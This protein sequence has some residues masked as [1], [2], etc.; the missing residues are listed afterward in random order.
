MDRQNFD[1]NY[2]D[3]YPVNLM[4]SPF[5]FPMPKL[6]VAETA[7][8]LDYEFGIRKTLACWDLSQI[9][10]KIVSGSETGLRHD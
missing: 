10:N 4:A 9:R 5:N 6:L 3:W 7:L 1:I 8:V 2:G